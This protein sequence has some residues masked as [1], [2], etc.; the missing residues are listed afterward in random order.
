LCVCLLLAIFVLALNSFP[1]ST[2]C[3]LLIR[4]YYAL[5]GLFFFLCFGISN[6]CE[7]SSYFTIRFVP[8]VEMTNWLNYKF[9]NYNLSRI[10][11]RHLERM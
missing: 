5:W 10:I 3:L 8:L 7:R 6:E 2:Y 9:F 1:V 4:F 11:N